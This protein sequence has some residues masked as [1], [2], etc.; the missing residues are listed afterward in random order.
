MALTLEME[1]RL[2]RAGLVAHLDANAAAWHANAQDAYDYTKKAFAGQLVRQDDIA[3]ALRAAVEID[4]PLR[5]VLDSKK[6]AQKFWI[7]FFTALVI[8]RTWG[9]LKK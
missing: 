4:P 2:Q 7:D 9:T 1:Q 3:K 5:K 6:L 8:D